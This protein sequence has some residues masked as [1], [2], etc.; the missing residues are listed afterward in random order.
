MEKEPKEVDAARQGGVWHSQYGNKSTISV[1]ASTKEEPSANEVARKYWY[2]WPS[3]REQTSRAKREAVEQVVIFGAQKSAK[4][5]GCLRCMVRLDESCNVARDDEQSTPIT[6]SECCVFPTNL[7]TEMLG[8][9][10]N[11][12]NWRVICQCS[13]E[14]SVK[15]LSYTF[16]FIHFDGYLIHW[17]VWH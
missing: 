4:K 11:N 17:R 8:K 10:V 5:C 7:L 2:Y 15:S 14:C 3:E 6:L 12:I 16:R 13:F 1:V 9:M